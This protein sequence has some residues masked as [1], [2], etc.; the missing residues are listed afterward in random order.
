MRSK[1]KRKE[2][3]RALELGIGDQRIGPSEIESSDGFCF[4]SE[5]YT[6]PRD[7]LLPR[8]QKKTRSNR[9]YTFRASESK[10][11]AISISLFPRHLQTSMSSPS[12]ASPSSSF[13]PHSTTLPSQEDTIP[14]ISS[15]STPSDPSSS[16][17]SSRLLQGIILNSLFSLVASIFFFGLV[18]APPSSKIP[19]AFIVA[20]G[21]ASAWFGVSGWKCWSERRE[22][23]LRIREGEGK[24]NEN[25]KKVELGEEEEEKKEAEGEEG[26]DGVEESNEKS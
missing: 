10:A 4:D 16:T 5:L 8:G 20:Y 23:K 26:G 24:E 13:S 12:S 17:D 14:Q 1:Q 6:L 25:E 7:D 2:K 11:N 9:I 15:S 19:T 22:L 18:F 21:G 3:G